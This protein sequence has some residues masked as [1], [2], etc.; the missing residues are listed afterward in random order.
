GALKGLEVGP[1]AGVV[2]VTLLKEMESIRM[3]AVDI[4]QKAV[5]MTEKNAGFHQ[6]PER[7]NAHRGD[8]RNIPSELCGGYD[9][10]I[11]NPP[12]LSKRE[13]L[14]AMP[15]VRDFEPEEA[16]VGGETGIESIV[17]IVRISDDH[18]VPGGFLFIEFG[19]GQKTM[20]CE[21]IESNG[22]F[23]KCEIIDDLARIPRVA[24]ARKKRARA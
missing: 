3:V 16:L 18:L 20:V 8:F 9:F 11:S 15:E 13:F 10:I 17:D 23:E 2:C 21:I 4:A 7:L 5:A 24:A 14:R 19:F 12:Y 22:W 1:G 6:V